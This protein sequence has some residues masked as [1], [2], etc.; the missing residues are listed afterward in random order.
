MKFINL[1]KKEI[2]ELINA[3][4]IL[5]LVVSLALFWLMGNVMQSVTTEIAEDAKNTNVYICD[6]D[7]SDVTH[8]LI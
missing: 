4:M 5:G 8:E 7:D 6:M 2:S 3:Q 1:L